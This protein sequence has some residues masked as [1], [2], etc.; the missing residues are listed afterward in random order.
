[1][2]SSLQ[3][4]RSY[5]EWWFIALVFL[6]VVL[7]AGG[8]MLLAVRGPAGQGVLLAGA[9][10]AVTAGLAAAHIARSRFQVEPTADG[11]LVRDRRGQ[12]ELRDDQVICASLSRKANYTN[13]VMRSTTRTFDVWVEGESGAEQVKMVSRLP[14]DAS[15]PLHP[16]IERVFDHLHERAAA[17]LEAG[18]PFEGE[19]WTLHSSELVVHARRSAQNVRFE[20]LAAAEIFDDH[21]C[22]WKYGQ[23][24]PVL[25]IPMPSANTH[26][27][28]RLLSERIAPRPDDGAP[29]A[30]DGLGRILFERKSGKTVSALLW[31]LPIAAVL[32]K[33]DP[34]LGEASATLGAGKWQKFVLITLPLSVPGVLAGTLLVFALGMSAFV[35]P[36]ILGGGK[37][38]VMSLLIRDQMGV[39]LDWPLG[40]AMSILLVVLTLILLFFYGRALRGGISGSQAGARRP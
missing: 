1:M 40:S 6:A 22:V 34:H 15:D 21:L 27:L 7:I 35:G 10:A 2:N 13:G 31:T 18:Q 39:T 8:T 23:D 37:V 9:I 5:K 20:E 19:G 32:Q 4:G 29:R 24:D 16:L 36:L 11:F 33:I 30:G 26:V 12:R 38:T 17:A 28:L 14:V 3:I 25:R